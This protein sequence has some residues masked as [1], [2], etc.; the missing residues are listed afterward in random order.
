MLMFDIFQR[1]HLDFFFTPAEQ[2]SSE[3]LTILGDFFGI[4]ETKNFKNKKAKKNCS[5]F[6]F[7]HSQNMEVA[8]TVK[9]I[10]F[11]LSSKKIGTLF[12]TRKRCILSWLRV[13]NSPLPPFNPSISRQKDKIMY[14]LI[15]HILF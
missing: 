6:L 8:I 10:Y 13:P 15:P 4:L 2:A 14:I 9:L 11:R 12:H 7:S 3:E 1:R 5:I